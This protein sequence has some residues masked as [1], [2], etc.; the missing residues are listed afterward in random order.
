MRNYVKYVIALSIIMFMGILAFIMITGDMSSTVFENDENVLVLNDITKTAEEQWGNLSGSSFGDYKTDFA[1]LDMNGNILFESGNAKSKHNIINDTGK[2]TVEAAVKKRI[3]YKYIV[4]DGVVVGSVI[5][6]DTNNIYAGLKAKLIIA[7]IVMAAFFILGAI[8][9]G[10]YVKK[11]IVVPFKRL[12]SFAGKVAHGKLD[13]PL[14]M[15]KDNMFGIFTESFDIMRE[16]LAESKK[17]EIALQKKERELVASLSHDLKTPITGIKLTSELLRAKVEN[18]SEGY[19]VDSSDM[20]IKIN[21]IYNKADQMDKLISDLF[22]STLDDLGEI[23]V[24]CQD[25]EAAIL[26]EIIKHNDDRGLAVLPKAPCLI[27]NIDRNRM[28]Q[29]IGNIITNSYKYANTKIDVEY[30]L[31]EDYLELKIRDF[32]PGVSMEELSAVTNKFYRGKNAEEKQKEGSGL[33]LYISKSLMEK[34]NGELICQR[35]DENGGF[36]VKLLIPLS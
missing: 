36:S 9:Y 18:K 33:G 30:S 34:M 20:L 35:A 28:N 6:F 29:V 13:E 5:L 25:E 32:G 19:P 3:P 14:M 21:N 11:N 12:E 2:L 22:S 1:V 16:E 23:K 10:A 7:F 4:K 31:V 15:E 24:N 17:R 26:N 27:I 8:V